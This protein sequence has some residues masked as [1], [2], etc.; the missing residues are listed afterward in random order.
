MALSLASAP[1]AFAPQPAALRVAAATPAVSMQS[2]EDQAKALNPVVG[3]FDPLG[4]GS[5]DFWSQGNA[6][7]LGFLRHAEIKHGRVAMAAFVGY[8]VQSN[9]IQF[10]FP[11]SLPE[12]T[13]A[14][15]AAGLTPPEQWDALTFEGKAQIIIF[16]GFLEFWG[17]LGGQHYMRGGKPGDYPDFPA[18]G[19]IPATPLGIPNLYDPAG[20]SKKMTPE[21]KERRLLAEINNGRAAMVS[22][23]T[24][25]QPRAPGLAS[26]RSALPLEPAPSRAMPPAPSD[27]H[28]GLPRGADHPGRRAVGPPP[29]G[30]L[31]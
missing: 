11:L 10:D 12:A 31:W 19:T 9:D 8:C 27:W 3:Y 6:A 14:Q 20:L 18:K 22:E 5:A 28:H 1:L 7:T 17:E 15:Y 13:N 23:P 30:V 4:L 21:Q 26:R 29:Q 16:I 24:T 25:Q 2:K